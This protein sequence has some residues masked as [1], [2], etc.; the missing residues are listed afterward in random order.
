MFEKN[1]LHV[2]GT[3][4]SLDDAQHEHCFVSHAHTDHSSAFSKRC[5]I[6]ASDETFIIMG[7]EPSPVPFPGIRLSSAGHMLGARQL[8]AE[9]DGG[10]F[11]YTGD[12]SL[13]DSYTSQKA[14]IEQ[15]NTLMIDTTYCLP[16]LNLPNRWQVIDRMRKFVSEND[17]SIIVFGAYLRGKTQELVR[18]LNIECGVAPVVSQPAAEICSRYEKCGLKL[19]YIA[20]GSDE[21]EETMRAPFVSIM[22]S[23]M[24][25]FNFGSKLSGAFGHEVKTAVATG[26]AAVSRFP[27][28]EAFP[29]SDHAD[30]KGTMRY[31]YESGA[32]KVICA[33]SSEE[34]AAAYLCKL[35]IAAVP[36]HDSGREVQT[37]LAK[38]VE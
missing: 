15:C 7:K 20:A 11:T 6:L 30:F 12:F 31:I 35:G 28:D 22:P 32:K 23:H 19:D 10:K 17:R 5:K 1:A 37:T 16:H 34:E 3:A 29:L 18:F 14:K 8:S 13:H 33:N 21:A 25:N 38:A 4:I 24:V 26:W 9:L 27:V 36:K 2:D